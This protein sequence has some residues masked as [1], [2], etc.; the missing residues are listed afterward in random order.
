MKK[1]SSEEQKKVLI[2]RVL[3]GGL[4]SLQAWTLL[5]KK[6]FKT[7]QDHGIIC[8]ILKQNN[9]PGLVQKEASKIHKAL[10]D[11]LRQDRIAAMLNDKKDCVA[12]AV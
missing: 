10:N 2:N 1:L 4:D 3:A 12:M 7:E 5:K 11:S 6:G 9:I 8:S